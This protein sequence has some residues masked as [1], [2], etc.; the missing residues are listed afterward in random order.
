MV[1]NCSSASFAL[2]VCGRMSVSPTQPTAGPLIENG[3]FSTDPDTCRTASTQWAQDARQPPADF[4]FEFRRH[5]IA[6]IGRRTDRQCLGLDGTHAAFIAAPDV[7]FKGV[8]VFERG[9]RVD[10]AIQCR[11]CLFQFQAVHGPLLRVERHVDAL[12]FLGRRIFCA[13]AFSHSVETIIICSLVLVKCA[14]EFF[15]ACMI[16]HCFR[17]ELLLNS[18][19]ILPLAC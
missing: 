2:S 18:L 12:D 11:P 7:A 16:A 6:A 10:P 17:F 19:I 4:S 14:G 1:G 13:R 5:Q 3:F 9:K 8:L 15:K